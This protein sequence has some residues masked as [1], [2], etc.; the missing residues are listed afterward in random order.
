M[1]RG[2]SGVKQV[3]KFANEDDFNLAKC[4]VRHVLRRYCLLC[5]HL[6]GAVNPPRLQILRIDR[7]GIIDDAITHGT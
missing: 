1:S 5:G 6:R 2:I 3:I 7:E 4:T